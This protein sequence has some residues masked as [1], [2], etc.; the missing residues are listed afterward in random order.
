MGVGGDPKD[1][2]CVYLTVDDEGTG[3]DEATRSKLFE[4]F[5]TT[6]GRGTGLG[7]AITRQIVEAHR[8][9][10][11]CEPREPQGT[12][13]RIKLPSRMLGETPSPAPAGTVD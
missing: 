12:R 9:V 10:L 1:E 11:S 7:L 5:F 3:I 6:K 8:G 13:F 4:P 2:E